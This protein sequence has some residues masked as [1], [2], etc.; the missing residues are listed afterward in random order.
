MLSDINEA[1]EREVHSFLM[2]KQIATFT[3]ALFIFY[4]LSVLSIFSSQQ[5]S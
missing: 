5:A 3:L 1:G 4:T 2:R